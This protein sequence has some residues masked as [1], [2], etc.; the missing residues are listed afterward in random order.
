MKKLVII[1]T[2]NEKENIENIISTVFALQEDF[3]VLVVDDSSPDGTAEIVK[4]L[5]SIYPH[6]LH[7]L[8]R[9]VK[10]GDRGCKSVSSYA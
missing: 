8:I 6:Q 3:H 2:Y 4:K 10:D 7:L 1:P 9:K 5:Q